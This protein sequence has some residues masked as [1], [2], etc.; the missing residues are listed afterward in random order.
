MISGIRRCIARPYIKAGFDT[1]QTNAEGLSP[2]ALAQRF[3]QDEV[4]AILAEK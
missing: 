2:L 4:V 3:S 1:D